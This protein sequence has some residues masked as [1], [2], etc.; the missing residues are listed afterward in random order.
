MAI[1]NKTKVGY[2]ARATHPD[3]ED[4]LHRI[5]QMKDDAKMLRAIQRKV[6]T[7]SID[8]RDMGVALGLGFD[9][10]APARIIKLAL[11]GCEV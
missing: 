9:Q 5:V 7:G 3:V 11:R 10:D 6:R 1:A 4:P 8:L 2:V